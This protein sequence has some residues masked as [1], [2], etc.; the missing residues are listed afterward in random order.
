M[1]SKSDHL[2]DTQSTEVFGKWHEG[3]KT[4]RLQKAPSASAKKS[5]FLVLSC[6]HWWRFQRGVTTTAYTVF[7]IIKAKR[8][9][10]YQLGVEIRTTETQSKSSIS[11]NQV[12]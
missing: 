4:L 10:H 6:K 2:E 3:R 8:C 12:A 5:V 7:G 11:K 1:T 9:L